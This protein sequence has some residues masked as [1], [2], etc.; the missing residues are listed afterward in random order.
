MTENENK[1]T[2]DELRRRAA[3]LAESGENPEECDRLYARIAELAPLS[4]A[5]LEPDAPGTWDGLV[6][7]IETDEGGK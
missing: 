5:D 4:P 7:D 6:D 2:L 1:E 3:E